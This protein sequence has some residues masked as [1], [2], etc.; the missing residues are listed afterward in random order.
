MVFVIPADAD[1]LGRLDGG[2]KR[3]LA[4]REGVVLE[5]EFL[6]HRPAERNEGL[7]P[8][9]AI[10]RLFAAAETVDS[11]SG[12]RMVSETTADLPLSFPV[13]STAEIA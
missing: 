2:E 7:A 13:W 1:D 8:E 10:S 12:S 5:T 4:Q 11:H 3:R 6:E 9:E